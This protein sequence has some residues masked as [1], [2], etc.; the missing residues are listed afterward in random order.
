MS[1]RA[2]FPVHLDTVKEHGEG[3]PVKLDLRGDRIVVVALNECGNNSTEVDL[4]DLLDWLRCN[5]AY[6]GVVSYG[7]DSSGNQPGDAEQV[8]LHG[9]NVGA[10]NT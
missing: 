7:H 10:R 5:R 1:D 8:L 4:L 9:I 3:F 6:L 2:A